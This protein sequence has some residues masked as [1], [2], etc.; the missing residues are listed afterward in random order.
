MTVG[1]PPTAGLSSGERT[2]AP[3]VLRQ[4]PGPV[5]DLRAAAP[6]VEEAGFEPAAV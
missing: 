1:V 3:R 4:V 5:P 6:G 2:P